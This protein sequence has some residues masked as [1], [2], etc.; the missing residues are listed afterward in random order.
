M[1]RSSLAAFRTSVFGLA[2]AVPLWGQDGVASV[3]VPQLLLPT[4]RIEATVARAPLTY[5]VQLQTELRGRQHVLTV[6]VL[7]TNDSTE[8]VQLRLGPCPFALEFSPMADPRAAPSWVWLP[9]GT[10][11][12]AGVMTRSC[13]DVASLHIVPP[14]S[15]LA[16]PEFQVAGLLGDR[17][18]RRLPMGRYRLTA[19][20]AIGAEHVR[21]RLGAAH[22]VDSPQ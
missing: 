3:G 16:L 20:M 11:D 8:A 12:S 22:I 19:D 13:A 21:V 6:A 14:G 15:S 17:R 1:N 2:M 18:V 7:V 10:I 4:H 9:G 5:R